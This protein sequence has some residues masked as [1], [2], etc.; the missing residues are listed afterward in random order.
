MLTTEPTVK[1]MAPVAFVDEDVVVDLK[2]DDR[3]QIINYAI[4]GALGPTSD[5]VRHSIENSLL[6][7]EFWPATW[8]GRPI[9]GN[10]RIS[11]RSS[12]IDVRG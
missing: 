1:F 6:F 7:T 2:L 4:V 5:Q 9:A 11:Y 3:G 12:R 10:I 8:F